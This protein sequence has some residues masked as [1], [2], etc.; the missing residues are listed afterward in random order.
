MVMTTVAC[1]GPVCTG[2][3]GRGGS[4]RRRLRCSGELCAVRAGSGGPLLGADCRGASPAAD[5]KVALLIASSQARTTTSSIRRADR[6]SWLLLLG[7][8]LW[9]T[10]DGP[11]GADLGP[12]RGSRGSPFR[13]CLAGAGANVGKGVGWWM[14]WRTRCFGRARRPRLLL[15]R[16][17]LIARRFAVVAGSQRLKLPHPRVARVGALIDMRG[18]GFHLG[19]GRYA[20]T[21][22]VT[23]MK[24]FS[25]GLIIL[26]SEPRSRR[27]MVLRLTL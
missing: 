6:V 24:I 20:H 13:V 21:Y 22:P 19:T 10:P 9:R 14:V 8:S 26:V 2:E 23:S 3:P 12:G 17:P 5:G 18:C 7:N 16:L 27:K 4:K 15:R 1:S 11:V 25:F